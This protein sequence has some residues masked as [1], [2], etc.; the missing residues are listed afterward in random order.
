M[1]DGSCLGSG[2]QLGLIALLVVLLFSAVPLAQSREL[3]FVTLVYRHGDR[4]P[5]HGY[6][7]DVHKESV[8][9]QGYGQLTQVG[10]K[11]HWDLGQELR[12]RYK[13]FLNESYNRHEIYVRSTDV[14]RTLMSAEANLAGLYPPEG[15]QI[16][17]PNITWQPIP[18]HTIPESEDQLLKFPISPCPAYVKLQEETRQSAEYINM[19][20]TYKA[21]LQMVAN[22]T[23]LSDCTLESVWSVYD[24][25]FC[26]KTHNFS[27]PTWA[28][29]D[30]LS[31]LNKLKDFS[32]VFLFGVHERVKKARLQGGVL[33][34]QILKN[35]TAAANNASN[36]LKL[37]AY[38]AHDSTLG[39]LQLA[40]DVYNGKQAPYASCHIFELYKED[41]G[42]FTVQMYFRNESGKTPY[43]VS[44]PGCAHACPLQDFQSLLQPIL[45]QDWEEECQT[46]SFIMTEET[47]IGLTIGAIALFIIIVVLMLLSCNEPKD[48]GYQHVSD[49]GD[50]HETKGLAM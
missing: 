7:T 29:A 10:M 34:D 5:V 6:P 15:P 16:F 38:S 1:A 17:N 40:L 20:T 41:S 13:G 43:P 44:L 30:V 25:L 46:T 49:E 22:K 19:T 45:A 26:E 23:G 9:P 2:P 4:S 28:T 24:T 42:N 11:Q 27:L 48:D 47:I 35:M 36:G 8:W 21:F 31:K 12:A 3:R 32:F 39:A 14:D 37:L 33:V 18:I 50:D